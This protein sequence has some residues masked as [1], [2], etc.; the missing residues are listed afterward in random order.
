VGRKEPVMNNLYPVSD[1][2][3]GKS[4]SATSSNGCSMAI[5]EALVQFRFGH[6]ADKQK[7]KLVGR[8]AFFN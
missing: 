5:R 2:V 8:H 4:M 1:W 3:T 7:R 6:R